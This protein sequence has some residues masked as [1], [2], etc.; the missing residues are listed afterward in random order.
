[1]KTVVPAAENAVMTF[2]RGVVSAWKN[3]AVVFQ[4]ESKSVSKVHFH[5]VPSSQVS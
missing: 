3:A 5:F 4:K 2:A 1:M